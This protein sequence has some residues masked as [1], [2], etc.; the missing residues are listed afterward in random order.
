MLELGNQKVTDVNEEMKS[1]ER[2]KRVLINDKGINEIT[3]EEKDEPQI[4][5]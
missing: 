5:A 2:V 1:D 4:M 3:K